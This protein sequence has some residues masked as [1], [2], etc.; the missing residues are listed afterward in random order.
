MALKV[1]QRLHLRGQLTFLIGTYNTEGTPPTEQYLFLVEHGSY[2]SGFPIGLFVTRD[3][4]IA[5]DDKD[6]I[7]VKA[8]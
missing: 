4:S 5:V 3:Y 8:K 1:G 2:L 6:L 7:S